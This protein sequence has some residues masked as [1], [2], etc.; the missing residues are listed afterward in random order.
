LDLSSSCGKK[1]RERHLFCETLGSH[2]GEYED[3]CLLG[4]Y[5]L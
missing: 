1:G 4:C 3:G 2:G 5:T